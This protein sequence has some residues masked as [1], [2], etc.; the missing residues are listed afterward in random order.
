MTKYW[1]SADKVIPQEEGGQGDNTPDLDVNKIKEDYDAL[2]GKYSQKSAE[3]FADKKAIFEFKPEAIESFSDKMKNKIVKEKY[4]YNTFDEAKAILGDGFY[5]PKDTD[6]EENS[7]EA[8]IE[9]LEK[10]RKKEA[11]LREQEALNNKIEL[12]FARNPYIL[13]GVE[14]KEDIIKNEMSKLSSTLPLEER[15]N[16]A[17]TLAESVRKKEQPWFATRTSGWAKQVKFTD[18]PEPKRHSGLSQL[19]GNNT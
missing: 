6:W 2:Y 5:K 16:I 15:I 10:E 19:F 3:E 7:T 13:D 1:D 12:H 11:Y 14:G 9:A 17:I 18:N 8:R 4:G